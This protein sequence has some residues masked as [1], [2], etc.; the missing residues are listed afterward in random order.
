MSGSK[1]V[2]QEEGID[3]LNLPVDTAGWNLYRWKAK[4][5]ANVCAYHSGIWQ[6]D[7]N[8]Q[9]QSF[10]EQRPQCP[11]WLQQ[12]TPKTWTTVPTAKGLRNGE[13]SPACEWTAKQQPLPSSSNPLFVLSVQSESR[14]LKQILAFFSSLVVVLI[15]K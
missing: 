12:A 11:L 1:K 3:S 5:K 13:W 2:G 7:L 4:T 8:M 6:I 9:L 14:V 15:E 10:G